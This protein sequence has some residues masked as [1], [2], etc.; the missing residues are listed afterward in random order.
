MSLV[1]LPNE[2]IFSICERLRWSGYM[3]PD[4]P[5]RWGQVRGAVCLRLV[6]KRFGFLQAAW[7]LVCSDCA[8]SGRVC[9]T[10]VTLAGHCE[11]PQYWLIDQSSP[12]AYDG[13]CLYREDKRARSL[14][15]HWLG[16]GEAYEVDGMWYGDSS[17]ARAV[18]CALVAGAYARFSPPSDLAGFFRAPWAKAFLASP[19]CFPELGPYVLDPALMRRLEATQ[20][21]NPAEEAGGGA[22]D[23]DEGEGRTSPRQPD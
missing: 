17:E 13:Y 1:A 11:G 22:G 16:F 20:F 4:K 3:P 12:P 19:V 14:R 2:L 6:S 8:V 23:G 10:T 21:V 7:Y 9:F 15:P 5:P 18:F